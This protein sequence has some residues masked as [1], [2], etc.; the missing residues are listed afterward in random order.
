M[1]DRDGSS[2]ANRFKMIYKDNRN[3]VNHSRNWSKLRSAQAFSINFTITFKIIDFVEQFLLVSPT[4]CD[5]NLTNPSEMINKDKRNLVYP[6]RN[7]SDL[8][9]ALAL[10]KFSDLCARVMG[11]MC[12]LNTCHIIIHYFI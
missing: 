1:V 3:L 8:R 2:F 10:L 6:S 5:R 11:K 4:Q 9:F 7:W 12:I